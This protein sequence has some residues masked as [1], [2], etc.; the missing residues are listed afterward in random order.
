MKSP[1]K[2][3]SLVIRGHKSSVSLEDAFWVGF[4]EIA[5]ERG[6]TLSALGGVLDAE[7]AHSNLSSCIR[8]AVLDYYMSKAA[9][10]AARRLLGEEKV[11]HA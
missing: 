10:S 1:V 8:L 2:K 3:R 11:L 7:R 4:K 5:S 9:Q 6:L